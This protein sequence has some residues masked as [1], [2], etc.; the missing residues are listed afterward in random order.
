MFIKFHDLFNCTDNS[1]QFL[2]RKQVIKKNIL[3]IHSFWFHSNFKLSNPMICHF[4][5][6]D[7]KNDNINY[8]VIKTVD[9]A[10]FIQADQETSL[11]NKY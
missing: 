8:A 11:E 6:L 7:D 1:Q 2:I 9:I 4:K 5:I 3:I 10:N